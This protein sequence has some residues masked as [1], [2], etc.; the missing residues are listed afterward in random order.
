MDSVDI[1]PYDYGQIAPFGF[2]IIYGRRGKGKTTFARW[3]CQFSPDRDT[4][5]FIVLVGSAKVRASWKDI[6]PRLFIVDGTVGYLTKLFAD[7]D[8]RI[9][10]YE[11]RGL[12]FPK[13]YH[14]TLILDDMGSKEQFMRHPIMKFIG[15]N[16]RQCY[17]TAYLLLQELTQAVPKVRGQADTITCLATGCDKT[18]RSLHRGYAS[19]IPLNTFKCVLAAATEDRGAC[20]VVASGSSDITKVCYHARIPWPPR[21]YRLGSDELW[22]Y[23]QSHYLDLQVLRRRVEEKKKARQG[24]ATPP[25]PVDDSLYAV[26]DNKRVYQV[27]GGGKLV[28]R[29]VQTGT[30][31]QMPA[32]RPNGKSSIVAPA[33]SRKCSKEKLE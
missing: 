24:K 30:G 2:H 27:K 5:I 8:K 32:P 19:T 9:K 16:G 12:P 22:A 15:S 18:I 31:E 10:H 17:V 3:T 21:W 13:K 4:G 25:G 7:Q 28:V 29:R 6:V 20:V 23:S 33:S 14:I 11:D 26:L 1:Q